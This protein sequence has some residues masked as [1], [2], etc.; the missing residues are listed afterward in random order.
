MSNS[1]EPQKAPPLITATPELLCYRTEPDP[2]AIIPARSPR[3]WMDET[4]NR[5]AYRCIPLTIANASG[6]EILCPASF[7]VTWWG[8][9]HKEDLR[10]QPIGNAERVHRFAQSHF[11]HGILTFH[12]GYLFRTS[13]GWGLWVRGMPNTHKRHLT[14]LDGLVETDWLAFTFTM[15]WRFTRIGS[16]EFREGEPFCF[17]TPVPHATLDGITPRIMDL[18]DNPEMAEA[19]VTY[20]QG[21]KDF[22]E[23]LA[24]RDEAA[25]AEGWQRHYVRG[26]DARGPTDSYH[27]SKRKLKNP[28]V[29]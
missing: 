25:L 18:A 6:W 19:Y 9:K 1:K 24:Q 7:R 12:P 3:A 26:E 22:N 20:A 14:P 5:F 15:N 2:P 28:V 17:I 21:R 13:P 27:I 4:D 11:G 10:I 29:T 23:K 16:V 8:T